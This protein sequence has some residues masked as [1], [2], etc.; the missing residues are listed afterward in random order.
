MT[1]AAENLAGSVVEKKEEKVEKRRALGRGLE[2]LLPGPRVV[3]P[4]PER[5]GVGLSAPQS[6]QGLKPESSSAA[7]GTAEAVPFPTSMDARGSGSVGEQQVPRFA[8]N[9]NGMGLPASEEMEAKR[10]EPALSLSK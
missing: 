1:T 2:S 4:S 6:P 10:A 9:D 3:A 7:N 5:S 8:R